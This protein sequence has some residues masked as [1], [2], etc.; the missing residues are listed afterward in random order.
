M[1]QSENQKNKNQVFI[2]SKFFD[3]YNSYNLCSFNNHK[4][5][6]FPFTVFYGSISVMSYCIQHLLSFIYWHITLYF[7]LFNPFRIISWQ[8]IYFVPPFQIFH[9]CTQNTAINRFRF[10]FMIFTILKLNII[11]FKVHKRFPNNIAI[12]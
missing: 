5:N 4:S 12:Q 1:K 6:L 11:Y 8:T 9:F 2:K 7:S 10:V 3:E